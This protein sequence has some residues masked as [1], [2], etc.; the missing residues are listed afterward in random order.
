M[1][2]ICISDTHNS[3]LELEKLLPANC[4]MI[5]H[6]G[7][8]SVDGTVKEIQEFIDWFGSLTYKYK[9]FIA[10]NHDL[11]LDKN[12]KAI[13]I[14]QGIIYLENSMVEVNGFKIWGSP[15]CPQYYNWAFTCSLEK[16]R[17][18]Y[19]EIPDDCD[20]I[21]NHSP[22]YGYLDKVRGGQNE[23]CPILK[24][25][26]QSINP[27]LVICGHIHESYGT[28]NDGDTTFINASIMT[29][30]NKPSNNPI[31]IEL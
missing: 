12:K 25:R 5:I 6:A 27:K 11:A 28:I 14:P 20:I 9:I 30:D 23:G 19:K 4:D 18:L 15:I 22:V 10:G 3:H 24:S 16:R 29:F 7:D 13:K 8:I 21:I 26:I 17:S 1:K 31:I 2:I